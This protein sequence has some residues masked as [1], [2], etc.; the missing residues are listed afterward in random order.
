MERVSNALTAIKE[1][2][3]SGASSIGGFLSSSANNGVSTFKG[4]SLGES[5]FKNIGAIMVVVLILLAA[6][7][8]IDLAGT[9][10]K[11]AEEA[12]KVKAAAAAKAKGPDGA[13][14]SGAGVASS[15]GAASAAAAA[16]AEAAN[17]PPG[18][19]II[20][21][22]VDIEPNTGLD[23]V[24]STDVA[25]TAPAISIRNELIEGFGAAYTE[26]ELEN[27]HTK[28]SDSFCVM[29]QKSPAELERACNTITT[30][31]MCGTKCC[32][33]WTK[34]T[35][36]EGDNDT[37]VLMNTAQSNAKDPSGKSDAAKLPGKCVAGNS[38]RPY[39]IKDEQNRERD[40][41]YYY[42]LGECVGGRGCMKKGAVKA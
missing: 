16:A 1:A 23:R 24:I 33:G 41:A 18:P 11:Q 3:D 4:T 10:K 27:I 5:F 7:I 2:G 28:C 9:A 39:D 20:K 14:T 26:K 19:S 35:G 12:A 30:R 17:K 42:Y 15:A 22:K 13:S 31:Q 29:H 40:I 8:Y 6:I 34:Y 32:C 25:W 36:F 37:A 21:R 38:T